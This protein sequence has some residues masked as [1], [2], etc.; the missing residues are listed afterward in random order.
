MG[1]TSNH[2]P[3]TAI[4]NVLTNKLPNM[5][6]VLPYN[7]LSAIYQRRNNEAEMLRER[8]AHYRDCCS[9][10]F[11]PAK[12][13][14]ETQK[15]SK[16]GEENEEL[17]KMP[18]KRR[19]PNSFRPSTSKTH[20]LLSSL[21]FNTH[22]QSIVLEKVTK[23][24]DNDA[25]N[26]GKSLESVS[27]SSSFSCVTCG[28]SSDHAKKFNSNNKNSTSSSG[29]YNS[30]GL[31]RL[32]HKRSQLIQTSSKSFAHLLSTTSD[33][34]ATRQSN[35]VRHLNSHGGGG[36]GDHSILE[37]NVHGLR[38]K[39]SELYQQLLN[40]TWEL[41]VRRANCFSQALA[42]AL[43]SYLSQISDKQ[44]SQKFGKQWVEHG[45]L[46]TY[47]G[48]LSAAGK[49][50]GMIEDASDSIDM[51]KGVKV[52]LVLAYD[53]SMDTADNG[54][55][56]DN[57]EKG[58]DVKMKD[59]YQL[60]SEK[61][62]IPGN[63]SS[64]LKW[65][66]IYWINTPPPTQGGVSA[67]S[68]STGMPNIL[69]CVG[70]EASFYNTNL[71][72]ELR[73]DAVVSFHPVLF[74]MGV[75]IR[76]WGAN[77]TASIAEKAMVTAAT[78]VGGFRRMNSIGTSLST[79]QVSSNAAATSASKNSAA[80][81]QQKIQGSEA[82]ATVAMDSDCET[83]D[84]DNNV[85]NIDQHNKSND[86][87]IALNSDA[88]REINTYAHAVIPIQQQLLPTKKQSLASSSGDNNNTIETG[89]VESS[90]SS[91]LTIA[92]SS[93][94]A[95]HPVLSSLHNSIRE[96]MKSKMEVAVLHDAANACTSLGGGSIVFCKSGKDRTAMQ[97]TLKQMRFIRE[98]Q[99]NDLRSEIIHECQNNGKVNNASN[100]NDDSSTSSDN[101]DRNDQ[102]CSKDDD[103]DDDDALFRHATIMRSHGTRLALCEKN[104]GQPKYAFN[105]LQAKFMPDLLKPPLNVIAGFL[106]GGK[107]FTDGFIES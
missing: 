94:S 33:L 5:G 74:Q 7:Y 34:L 101:G 67:S 96:S 31:R 75:D 73:S 11:S 97:V 102:H 99:K 4:D 85:V 41:A 83:D 28:A 23:K 13:N 76:Q 62:P 9:S 38:V 12:Q 15:N 69:V 93:S 20:A 77:A 90:S 57:S 42:I 78:T 47:E 30:G 43:T 37:R 87:L 104:V 56:K 59:N 14:D 107:A 95:L 63:Q 16:V 18:F 17:L 72:K 55:G 26:S 70:V 92:A 91:V 29:A 88:F 68:A 35:Y 65:V 89:E 71:P 1:L 60:K 32:L 8:Y 19:I 22:V 51:L 21:P 25:S 66:E 48:M 54:S 64:P 49:E 86:L 61:V 2:H 36:N 50:M 46:L 52:K 100:D 45:F 81:Q 98:E 79:S 27:T 40:L 53:S 106:K 58:N 24:D 80:A 6:D 39:C 44:K 3:G 103:D 82:V 105:S 10:S 84:E